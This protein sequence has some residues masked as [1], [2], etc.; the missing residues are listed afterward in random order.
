MGVTN[1]SRVSEGTRTRRPALR[2][3]RCCDWCCARRCAKHSTISGR[4]SVLRNKRLVPRRQQ[5]RAKNQPG[6][7]RHPSRHTDR[8]PSGRRPDC[9]SDCLQRKIPRQHA[10]RWH[11]DLCDR[12]LDRPN[13]RLPRHS[14]IIRLLRRN[15][16]PDRAFRCNS[17][18][19][20]PS[21]SRAAGSAPNRGPVSSDLGGES[22]SVVVGTTA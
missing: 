19:H 14:V 20:S 21:V 13:M 8:G 12:Q 11:C 4:N 6:R 18:V 3:C 9:C 5:L 22:R 2:C 15:L 10:A 17:R 1:R 7:M 16:P